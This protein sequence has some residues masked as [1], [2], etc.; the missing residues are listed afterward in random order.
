MLMCCYS[1]LGRDVLLMS[2]AQVS[3]RVQ[4]DGSAP[5]IMSKVEKNHL[6]LILLP[7]VSQSVLLSHVCLQTQSSSSR[8][9][10]C[11][12]QRHLERGNAPCFQVCGH[13]PGPHSKRTATHRQGFGFSSVLKWCC[14]ESRGS[15]NCGAS[16]RTLT[17][18]ACTHRKLFIILNCCRA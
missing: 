18:P 7:S 17:P 16:K 9:L 2:P 4:T 8:P 11:S 14:C 1:K 3:A 13:I 15:E 5:P 10:W 12:Q 6:F